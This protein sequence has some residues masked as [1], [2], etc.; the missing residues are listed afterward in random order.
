M[1][2]KDSLKNFT[3]KEI[4]EVCFEFMTRK[5]GR[6]ST[7]GRITEPQLYRIRAYER[8]LGWDENPLRLAAFIDKMC[9][10]AAVQWLTPA[11]AG[12]IIEALKNMLEREQKK[13]VTE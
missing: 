2:G 7:R 1:I 4:N 11:Q 5:D 12:K 10:A 13:E 9:H 6:K 8:L 3:Q